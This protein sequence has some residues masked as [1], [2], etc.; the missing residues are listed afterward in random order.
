MPELVSVLIP[1]YNAEKLIAE[2]IRSV[3]SQTWLNKEI[4]IVDD[5]GASDGTLQIAKIFEFKAVKVTT[6]RN[7]SASLVGHRY[8]S[9]CQHRSPRY[10]CQNYCTRPLVC[11]RAICG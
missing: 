9:S 1:A 2:T 5:G 7:M 4:I 3:L 11:C 10:T 6:Q 8:S